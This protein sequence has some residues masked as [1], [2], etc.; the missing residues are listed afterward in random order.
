MHVKVKWRKQGKRFSG[1]M[2]KGSVGKWEC[3]AFLSSETFPWMMISLFKHW[4]F[5]TCVYMIK[6]PR[7]LA[8][9]WRE[10][11]EEWW[12]KPI[13]WHWRH[14]SVL[15][16]HRVSKM[17]DLER[18]FQGRCGMHGH[19]QWKALVWVCCKKICTYCFMEAS[20]NCS[21]LRG[22]FGWVCSVAHMVCVRR[23]QTSRAVL[24]VGMQLSTSG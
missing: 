3:T 22:K 1:K 23:N 21:S 15:T 5:P 2:D 10:I 12:A 9:T 6:R 18:D 8:V 16:A 20:S 11:W 19:S 17:W 14:C 24:W 4:V 13:E 7:W